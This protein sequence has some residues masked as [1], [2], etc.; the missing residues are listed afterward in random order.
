MAE[1]HIHPS[2]A[3]FSDNQS[4]IRLESSTVDKLL[5]E[6]CQKYPKLKNTILD[7]QGEL[8]PYV[9]LYINGESIRE[10]EGS[11]LLQGSDKIELIT[12]LVGG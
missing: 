1:V 11:T 6:L 9:N 10:K 8:N 5:P 4:S 2:L 7:A 3:R 12:A